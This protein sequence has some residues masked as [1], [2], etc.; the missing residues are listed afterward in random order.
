MRSPYALATLSALLLGGCPGGDDED[1]VALADAPDRYGQVYCERLLECSALG[2]TLLS[3]TTCEFAVWT[4]R[5]AGLARL[6]TWVADQSVAYDGAAMADCLDD[7]AAAACPELS[8]AT[9]ADLGRCGAAIAGQ[10]ASGGVCEDTLQCQPGLYC[11]TATTCPGT[12]Q[13]RGAAGGTCATDDSCAARLDCADG[14]CVAFGLAG[15]ACGQSGMTSCALGFQCDTTGGTPGTCQPVT[16]AAAAGAG[17]N[18]SGGVLCSAG[19]VCAMVNVTPAT[20]QCQAPVTQVGP[21]CRG[22]AR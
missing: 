19:L 7:V 22:P 11:E 2:L 13:P 20:Y 5:N 10:L 3:Q 16:F 6:D 8:T 18:P 1:T 15:A 12:C 4:Y 17:C 21:G 14:A 9:L